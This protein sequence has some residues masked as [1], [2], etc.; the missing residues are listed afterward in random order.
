[1]AKKISLERFVK[2]HRGEIV[3]AVLR[4]CSNP[5]ELDDEEL[6]LWVMND[7]GLYSWAK[8]EGMEENENE[9]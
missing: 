7:E 5:P 4:A 2:D 8:H 9:D 3:Q 1:M 6:A